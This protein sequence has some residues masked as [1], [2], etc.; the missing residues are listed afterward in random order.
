VSSSKASLL[1]WLA[2]LTIW[3]VWGSTYLAI[4]VAVREMAPFAAGSLRFFLAGAAMS[5]IAAVVE[6]RH[7]PPSR[8]QL[9]HYAVIGFLFL[10]L[11]N[12]LVMWSERRIPSGIAA[13]LVATVPLWMTFLDGLRPGG[14]AWTTRAWL[15]TA[16]GLLGV[17]LVAR[18]EGG[19]WS[20]HVAGILALQVATIAWTIG[21]LYS[22]AVPKK[23]PVLTASAIE[24]LVGAFA[25]LV[26]SRL[27]GEDLGTLRAASS[28]AWLSLGYLV[29][30][31]S[32]V[33]FTAFSYCLNELPAV[34]VGTYAYVNPVVAVALGA[35]FLGE[36]LSAWLLAGGALILTAVV[37]TTL[38]S[39]AP[40]PPRKPEPALAE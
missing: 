25:L 31:G 19:D 13:L 22:Q 2:L 34:V 30:F 27:V 15:G 16:I 29:V 4:R 17:F 1:P 24:M 20:A 35:M 32:L 39:K 12:G 5:V 11:G 28:H 10:G 3:L 7:G 26:E 14:Q 33:G 38:A 40:A 18:P 37:L 9:L 23:L 6:R 36:P 21:A 8:S